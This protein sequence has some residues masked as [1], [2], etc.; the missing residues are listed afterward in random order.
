MSGFWI[1]GVAFGAPV[2]LKLDVFV[3][4]LAT[5]CG[6]LISQPGI[7][8]LSSALEACSLNHWTAR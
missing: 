3:C 4:L 5:P 8:P 6:I 7:E 2:F 1:L